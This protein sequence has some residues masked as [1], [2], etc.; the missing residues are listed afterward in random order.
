MIQRRA[1]ALVI[2]LLA[3]SVLTTLVAG[4]QAVSLRQAAAGRETLARLRAHWAARGG[5]ESTLARLE[6]SLESGST[7]SAY[8]VPDD[9]LSASTGTVD[10]AHWTISH[11]FTGLAAGSR[12]GPADPHAKVNV[13]LM[14]KDDLMTLDEM[15]EDVADSILDWIDDDDAPNPLGAEA[16]YY[17][18]LPSPYEPRNGPM[19]SLFELELVAGV[20]SEL[21]R[22]EDWNLDGVLDANEDDGDLSWPPDNADGLL[23]AAWSAF[24]TASSWEPPLAVSGRAPLNLKAAS[25]EEL[26]ARIRSLDL[27]Q[28]QTILDFAAQSGALLE[29]LVSTSLTQIASQSGASPTVRNLTDDQLRD[30]LDEC[31][32][33]DPTGEP[34]PGRVNLNTVSRETLGFITA[35][36]PGLADTLI[37]VRDASPA[38]F[39]NLMDLLDT[40]VV[41]RTRLVSISR[42]LTV[43]PGS[44]RITSIGRDDATGIESRIVCTVRTAVLPA[45]IVEHLAR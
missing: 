25:A 16:G 26:D 11:S 20:R 19:P 43:A 17:S 42:V 9:M 6:A 38:G 44:Y 45:P 40:G 27:A 34:A 24:I 39:V 22:G 21:V 23:D 14:T 15:T 2:V 1:L 35:V 5:V 41:S 31:V 29:D 30:L 37:L 28:A 12:E 18:Q 32:I 7:P 3:L 10:G 36:S 13:N 33:A 8:A 4:V